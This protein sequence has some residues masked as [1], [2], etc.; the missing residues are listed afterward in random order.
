M[1][2]WETVM[3]SNIALE[4]WLEGSLLH[5]IVG[6]L[7]NWRQG[8]LIMQYSD[9]IGATLVA[10]VLTLS[11]FVSTSLIGVLLMACGGFWVLLTL[12]DNPNAEAQTLNTP[13]HWLV[14]LFGIISLIATALS[15]VKTDALKGLIKLSL[16]L[17]FF[18]FSARL[19]RI[20][21]IRSSLITT[22]LLT[23]LPV[24]VYGIRQYFFG[25]KALA[26]W[27][28][29]SSASADVTRVYSYLGNPNLLA[30]YLLPAVIWGAAAFWMWRGICPKILGFVIFLVNSAC[31]VLTYSR[32]GWIGFVVALT[33]FGLLAVHWWSVYLPSVWKDRALPLALLFLLALF[34]LAIAFV[35][36]IRDRILTMFA[37][38]SD[39][40]NNFRINVWIGAIDMVKAYPIIGIGPGNS[41]FNKI[42]PLFM[43]PKYTALSAYSVLLE[44]AVETGLV[45]LAVFLWFLG[46]LFSQGWQQI[47]QLREIRSQ[48]VWWLMGAIAICLG[49]M[50]HG[51]VDTVWYRPQVNTL[52]WFAVAIV[53][54]YYPGWR[55][56]SWRS[57]Y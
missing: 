39:S 29:P 15:P 31:L 6:F 42:Y 7:R 4:R 26:T 57:K 5:R 8:S 27:V 46:V 37:G 24:S 18:Y 49:M 35:A 43:Q 16:Y 11:P 53:A 1:N 48:E 50:A 3:L 36:P 23:S 52:W 55:E 13:I 56:K 25:A 34:A 54:S 47:Q 44:T 22:Y 38:R 33:A 14:F 21:R 51:A 28:D 12:S 10:L 17:L 2:V 19:T 30:A 9:W 45:G 41:A 40:S 20:P 32:G